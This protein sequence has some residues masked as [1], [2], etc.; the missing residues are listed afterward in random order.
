MEEL[1]EKIRNLKE[2]A[3]PVC[4][5]C[6]KKIGESNC[7]GMIDVLQNK[8]YCGNCYSQEYDLL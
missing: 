2:K 6:G 1:I 7:I 4:C 3:H 5:N 8:L